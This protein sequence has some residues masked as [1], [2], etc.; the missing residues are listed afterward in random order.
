MPSEKCPRI[1]SSSPCMVWCAHSIAQSAK[2]YVLGLLF[3]TNVELLGGSL[4]L[5]EGVT[6]NSVSTS[7]MRGNCD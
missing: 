4:T 6:V 2:M 1:L 5:G 7:S 3:L